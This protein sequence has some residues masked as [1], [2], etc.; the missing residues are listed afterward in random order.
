MIRLKLGKEPK[1]LDLGY[2]VTVT[3]D[4]LHSAIFSAAR[5]D[6]AVPKLKPDRSNAE[7]VTLEL[8]KAI[9]RR[10]ITAWDGIG[11]AEG[12]VIDPDP[13]GINAMLDVWQLYESFNAQFVAPFLILRDE[14]NASAPLPS[15]T[16]A[17]E[18]AIATPVLSDASIV[19]PD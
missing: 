4:P 1:I 12:T 6:D 11:D 7:L 14:G 2:G 16:S 15:G 19:L 18:Q 17:G 13:V 8:V 3:C 5:N 9:A 10:T